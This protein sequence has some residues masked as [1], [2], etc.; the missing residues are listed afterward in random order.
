[1]RHSGVDFTDRDRQRYRGGEFAVSCTRRI[2]FT[3]T[4]DISNGEIYSMQ[5]D[6]SGVVRLTF[7]P[8]YDADPSQ[9]PN[10]SRIAFTSSRDPSS[11][12]GST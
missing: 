6:G 7:E 2:L 9:S 8:A 4:R 1:M 10:G 3:S 11:G 12:P 5:P